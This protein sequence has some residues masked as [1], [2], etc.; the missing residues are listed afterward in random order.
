MTPPGETLE[1]RGREGFTLRL[2]SV[3]D[4]SRGV[5]REA[6]R[7]T[8]NT[9]RD[10]LSKGSLPTYQQHVTRSVV[11]GK[12]ADLPTTRHAIGCQREACRLTNNT[13]R[14]RLSKG[15]L[16]TYQQ[17]VTRSVVKGKPADLPTTRSVGCCFPAT[18]AATASAS[19]WE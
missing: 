4:T 13:S 3:E 16:P 7:L 2:A 11:K 17:H 15:S 19:M 1:P 14:D 12:P 9:S 8:N 18:S 10:R 5:Q 6:C